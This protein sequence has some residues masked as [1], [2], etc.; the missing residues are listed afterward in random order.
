MN[1]EPRSASLC[2]IHPSPA[3][4]PACKCLAGRV[5]AAVSVGGARIDLPF[6]I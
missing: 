6:E 2:S 3:D 1:K 5:V 4:G